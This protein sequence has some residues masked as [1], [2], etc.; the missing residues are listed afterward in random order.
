MGYGMSVISAASGLASALGLVKAPKERA[1]S[2]DYRRVSE[3]LLGGSADISSPGRLTVAGVA[4]FVLSSD[5]FLREVVKPTR[6]GAAPDHR[7]SDDVAAL[8]RER[9]PM[10]A[11]TQAGLTEGVSHAEALRLLFTDP[12]FLETV[13]AQTSTS[14]G[15]DVFLAGG[16]GDG[17]VVDFVATLLSR[18]SPLIPLRTLAL[19][20]LDRLDAQG[21][22][23][24][25]HYDFFQA[26][27]LFDAGWYARR[28]ATGLVGYFENLRHYL[29]VGER[30][31]AS[32]NPFLNI[33]AYTTA[34]PD[35]HGGI[36]SGHLSS[37]LEHLVAR[38]S[39]ERRSSAC[40]FDADHYARQVSSKTV[41]PYGSPLAHYAR[42]GWKDGVQPSPYFDEAWYRSYYPEVAAA[43]ESGNYP[44]GF[45]YFVQAGEAEGHNPCLF[46]DAQD[47]LDCN[48]D[49]AEAKIASPFRHFQQSGLA[50]KRPLD[51]PVDRAVAAFFSKRYP[52]TSDHIR[53]GRLA[54]ADLKPSAFVQRSAEPA[55]AVKNLA[56]AISTGEA[57]TTQE[58]LSLVGQALATMGRPLV[59][60][61][62]GGEQQVHAGDVT[63]FYVSGYAVFPHHPLREVRVVGAG[64]AG[65]CRHFLY[66]R[67]D[68]ADTIVALGGRA[69]DLNNGFMLWFE[70]SAE[71]AGQGLHRVNLEFTFGEAGSAQTVMANETITVEVHRRPDV[72]ETEASIQVAMASYNPPLEPFKAQ[73]ESILANPRVHLVISDDAS[74]AMG[75]TSLAYYQGHPRVDIDIN[76]KNVG[77]IAN[78]ER[79]LYQ[80]SSA[81]EFVMFSDQ[82]DLWNRDKVDT[83]VARLVPGV[84]CVF[85]D[86]RITTDDGEVIS[87]TFW[88]SRV[89]HHHNS[90]AVGIANT[91]T[92]AAAA[93]PASLIPLLAPFPRYTK[94]LYHDQW[95]SV[96]AA[97]VGRIDYVERPLYDYIQHG[98]NVLGFY[99]SRGSQAAKWRHIVARLRKARRTRVMEDR[100]IAYVQLALSET[101]LLM[102]RYV[103]WQEA[104]IRVAA[105]GDPHLQRVVE[106]V[107]SAVRGEAFDVL[108][109]KKAWRTL[110]RESGGIKGLLSIDDLLES[111]VLARYLIAEGI[112]EPQ[113]LAGHVDRTLR[114]DRIFQKRVNEKERT[115]FEKKVEPLPVARVE[116]TG[117]S[118]RINLFLPEIALQRFFGGYHSKISLITRLRERGIATRLVLVD[119]PF[120]DHDQVAKVIGAFPELEVGLGESEIVA[121]GNR[122]EPLQLGRSDVLMATTWWSAHMVNDLRQQLGRERFLY[123]IQEYEPFTFSMGTWYRAA[124]QT[125]DFPHDAVF[126]T[127]TLEG[128]FRQQSMGVFGPKAVA[129]ATSQPFRNPI[130]GLREISRQP[131]AGRRPRMLFY[132]RPQHNESRNMYEFGLAAL[133]LAAA[134]LGDALEG[135]E[136][137]GVGSDRNTAIDIGSGRSLRMI[138]KL[139]SYSYREMLAAS[140]VGLA[141]MYTP[142][143]SLVPLEMAAAGMVTVTNACM[144]K[145]AESFVGVSDL[146][147]VAEPDVEAIA[148]ELV[149]AFRE[150]MAGEVQRPPLDWPT[151]PAEAFSDAWIDQFMTTA[152]KSLT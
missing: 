56:T 12:V 22:V 130:T 62:V 103:M 44:N 106:H 107:C 92:G 110:A 53:E 127:E 33:A 26:S 57:F 29:L 115:F 8:A 32:P 16:E 19:W 17:E 149:R 99:G 83:L 14:W 31:G 88:N 124:E 70:F 69:R 91:V 150:A 152:K 23:R 129:G 112:A 82:D 4:Q 65:P 90:L 125:Y 49:L 10:S 39:V 96:L 78:F 37:L 118:P 120:V 74:P 1:T 21:L 104:L 67:L 15:P 117:A 135:W 27:P 133:R 40:H 34:H 20:G 95:L 113:R 101:V 116:V 2:T 122:L 77:F 114:S 140:D 102:Q 55:R 43:I 41:A 131:R 137:V 38:D 66:P 71:A 64:V 100:D 24:Y 51:R 85:S 30:T 76:T 128:F 59:H 109:L 75:A 87:P 50:E 28:Y 54:R 63:R 146:I 46:F 142:H 144:S 35:L 3:L 60:V 94:G 126:S 138:Q 81:A 111:V 47:Y 6:A 105:W 52:D 80:C 13:Y 145:T 147:R 86:M 151:S 68:R 45:S 136:L 58:G 5:V 42:V 9:M 11:E 73:V 72:S 79:S 123:F 119:E 134:E 18:Q 139:D 97:A 84:A 148:A 108:F 98:G 132:A 25:G 61:E 89:V 93:F 7:L 36:A 48:P 143:P 121:P 141:L